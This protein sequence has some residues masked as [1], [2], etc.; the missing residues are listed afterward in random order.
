MSTSE[1]PEKKEQLKQIMAETLKKRQKELYPVVE[2]DA[3]PQMV[4]PATPKKKSK[5]TKRDV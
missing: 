2:A 5:K 4:T 1:N 3:S